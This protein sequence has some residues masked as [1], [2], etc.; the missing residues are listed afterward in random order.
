MIT[1]LGIMERIFAL[2]DA[3]G[4]AESEDQGKKRGGLQLDEIE[5][6][7]TINGKGEIKVFGAGGEVGG[8]GAIRLKYKRVSE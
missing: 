2:A 5:L 7:I 1:F 6:S 8:S 4:T 3:Q